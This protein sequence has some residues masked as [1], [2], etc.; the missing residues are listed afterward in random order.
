M[1]VDWK[2]LPILT[3]C[4]AVAAAPLSLPRPCPGHAAGCGGCDTEQ[5]GATQGVEVTSAILS[6]GAAPANDACPL[7]HAGSPETSGTERETQSQATAEAERSL[8][9]GGTN[10]SHPDDR[11]RCGCDVPQLVQMSIRSE[12]AATQPPHGGWLAAR[13]RTVASRELETDTPPPDRSLA[14]A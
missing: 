14:L 1:V 6:D 12:Y 4:W 3:L 11:H 10:P 5:M 13:P 8:D 2:L 9:A 7:C